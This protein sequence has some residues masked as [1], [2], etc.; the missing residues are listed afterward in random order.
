MTHTVLAPEVV[1]KVGL[2]FLRQRGYIV[3][4][5]RG[6]DKAKMI[7]DL[8]DCDALI[9]RIATVDEEMFQ[10]CPKLKVVAKHG[11]GLDAID[12]EAAK[13]HN[14]RVVYAPTANTL[15]VAEHAVS[16]MIACAKQIP[17][18]MREYAKGN[19]AVK[20][21][22]I[23]V[24]LTGKTL[25]LIGAGRIAR[26]VARIAKGGFNMRVLSADP[27]VKPGSFPDLLEL[28]DRETL[29]KESDFVSIHVPATPET[30]KSVGAKDFALMKPTAFLINTAR[31]TVVDEA[32]LIQAL[33]QGTIKG[34]GMDVSDP[35]PAMPEN[36]LFAMN[37]VVMTPHIAAATEEAMVRVIMDAVQGL[38]DV[39]S[40]RE[41]KYPVV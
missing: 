16:L 7:E 37:Q 1:A 39:F 20:D 34:V 27:F 35:E 2:D 33:R 6:T 18:K 17:Y 13:R 10:K 11:V 26:E 28:V 23:N 12:L 15:S 38:D 41:P 31:G 4:I 29:L 30:E 22:D 5:G 3:K 32:A 40:G 8:Q 24:E 14:C 9:V 19:F 36:P 25:G 21:I